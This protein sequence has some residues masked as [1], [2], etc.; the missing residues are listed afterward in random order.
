[1]RCQKCFFDN[2]E[3]K[4]YCSRCGDV[5]TKG[6]S[7]IKFSIRYRKLIVWAVFI[8]ITLAGLAGYM[9]F[10]ETFYVQ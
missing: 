5:I 1:M 9:F 3:G 8:I 2:E 10:A 6:P 4:V 7:Q